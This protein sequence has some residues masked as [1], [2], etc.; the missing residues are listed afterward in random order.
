MAKAYTNVNSTTGTFAGWLSKANELYYDMSTMIVTVADVAAPNSSNESRTTGN[1]DIQGIFSANNIVVWDTLAGGRN[2]EWANT[3]TLYIVSNTQIGNSSQTDTLTVYGD[4][5]FDANVQIGSAA[6]DG[7]T[8]AANTVVNGLSFF[9][10]NTRFNDNVRLSL[11]TDSDVEFYHNGSDLRLKH[12]SANTSDFIIEDTDANDIFLFNTDSSYLQITRYD[13]S[14]SGP[15]LILRDQAP[16]AND[17]FAGLIS[18]QAAD[19]GGNNVQ[20]AK[21]IGIIEDSVNGTEDGSISVQTIVAGTNRAMLSVN[22]VETGEIRLYHANSS[23]SAVKLTTKTGGVLIT[24]EL[25]STTLDVNGVANISGVVTLGAN[26]NFGDADQ[27]NFGAAADLQIFHDASHSHIKDNGTGNLKISSSQIDFLGGADGAETMATMVDDGAVTLYHNNA[28]KFATLA[29]GVVVTGDTGTDTLTVGGGYGSTGLAIA[30]TGNI[31]TNGTLTVDGL[32]TLNAGIAVDT[33]KFTVADTSGNV[34]TAGTL[35]VTG[36]STLGIINVSG[37]AS[38]DAGIDVDGAFTVADTSGNV[39]TSGTLGV[40]GVS[41]LGIINASGLA[42]LDAGIDVDGAFTVSNSS[43]NIATSGTLGVT[44][45]STL[46]II[47]ASG[48]ASLNGGIAVDANFTVNGTSGATVIGSTLNVTGTSTLV[49]IN[50]SGLASLDGGINVNDDFTVDVNGNVVGVASTFSGLTSADGGIDVNS[51]KFTVAATGATVIAATTESTSSTTGALKVGGGAGIAGDLF[52]GENVDITGNLVVDGTATF[53]GNGNFTV[54]NSIVTTL[55]VVGDTDIGNGTADTVTITARVDSD[56]VPKTDSTYDLGTNGLRYAFVFG[57]QFYSSSHVH[58]QGQG[59]LRFGDAD[60]SNYVALKSPAT[61]SSNITWTLPDADATTSGFALVSNGSGVLS[62][63]AAGATT[64]SDTS[65]NANELIYFG[66]T[67]SG[68]V[69]A[70][71]H[72]AGL[73]YNPSTG[74]LTSAAFAGVASSAT[75]AVTLTGLASTVT[76]L[77]KVDGGTAASSITAAGADRVVYNDAGVMKQVALTTLDT[78][79]S[80]TTKTLTNKTLTSPTLNTPSIGTSFTFDSIT[81]AGIQTSAESFVDNDTSLMTSGAINDRIAVVAQA[82]IDADSSLMQLNSAATKSAG[83]LTFND[84][85]AMNF[86]TGADAEIFHS[87]NHLFA[88]INTGSFYIRDGSDSNF[89]ALQFAPTTGNLSI[90][91]NDAAATGPTIT[92]KHDTASP[93]ASDEAG[94]IFFQSNNAAGTPHNYAYIDSRIVDPTTDSEDGQLSIYTLAAGAVK[95]TIRAASGVATLYHLSNAKLAT[96]SG[97][98]TITGTATATTFSGSGASLTALPAASLTGTIANA[99]LPASIS[100][101][102]T[103]TAAKVTVTNSATNTNFPV[104]FHNES[105]GLLD[106]TGALRYNPST[107]TL[108]VPNLTVA[109]TT[110]QVD[111]VTMNAANAIV[112]EGATPDNFETT[113]TITD[114]TADRTITLPNVT[115]TV[116]L[117]SSDIT[118]NAATATTLATARTIGGTSFN[119][120]AN[121]AVALAATATKLAT[122]RAI[123][124]SGAVTGTANFDGSGAINIVTTATADPTITL[125][126]DLTGSATLTNLGNATLT[127]TIAA[128][129]VETSMIAADA[130]TGTKIA[131]NAI[132]SEHYVNASIDNEHIASDA[133]TG[134]K[135]ADNAINSEHY[136]NGSIDNEHIASD[137]ITGTKIADNA[138]NSEHY[139][140][141]SIDAA[142]IAT[143]AI[144]NT[145]IGP[146]AVGASELNVA[147]NGTTSQFLRSDG[148]GTFTWA[149]PTDTNTTYTAGTGLDLTGTTF[150]LEADLRDGITAIGRDAND[151]IAI[152]TTS[153]VFNLDGAPRMSITN[154]GNLITTGDITAFG[155]LSDIRLKENIEPITSALDKVSQ[156]GGYTFNYKKNPDVRMTGVIAQ[157]VEKVLP[158]VIYTTTDINSD[159]ENLAVR[160]ENMIG[161]LVEAIKELKTEVEELKKGK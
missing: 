39:V 5:T 154:A 97:G 108:L 48:L 25:E 84:S 74:T 50:A 87:G 41:T 86:G 98:V 113:L 19:S 69:T 128:T 135:I 132:N 38:L 64:T 107:G 72:D 139:V 16:S 26:A 127:A 13:G 161:L 123:Q 125:G 34:S 28:V 147:G 118:G 104:V 70:V 43:G 93:A 121:I 10:A 140:N 1:A 83:D 31:Q 65:T 94:Q 100:S 23:S 153:I 24:G 136:V 20:Y 159:E 148:D 60:N 49:A 138:I 114:P 12:N 2:E 7:L 105:N 36:I 37:L 112:F 102:I 141:G 92:L 55:S 82:T 76:E 119:G 61:V 111:T 101:D 122:T 110:T 32:A 58:I 131:D 126:G 45:V 144:T 137:A 4:A 149:V 59:N 146:S 51:A 129:S 155:S 54:N 152:G 151:Y 78:Y 109:G 103:G 79:F 62:W 14:T 46:G 157:E 134:T 66:D 130:I 47:N 27:A 81:V 9:T 85:V 18:F 35:G 3:D 22:D 15:S 75:T 89:T 88:D 117:T 8:I 158:E 124:V 150:S 156:I 6:T 68:A 96:A 53:A 56:I 52:V 63:A 77:N 33:N 29:T 90:F 116:A 71:H 133:I 95:H 99:R 21:I 44:G 120:S 106:D 11:G 143:N 160:Y 42:S 115:G 91:N 80:G 30:A 57:D 40:T 145:Q 17:Q 67:T 73:T 142:H